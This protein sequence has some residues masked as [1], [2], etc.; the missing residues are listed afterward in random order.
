[1]RC[2]PLDARSL[3]S[4]ATIKD[5]H[6]KRGALAEGEFRAWLDASRLPYVYA[7][8]DQESVPQHFRVSM[9]RPDYLVALPYVATIAFDVKSKTI[10]EG[11]FLFDVSEVRRLAHFGELFAVASYF[12]C[13]DPQGSPISVWF[14]AS[15]LLQLPTRK[16]KGKPVCIVPF[17]HGVRLSMTRPFQDALRDAIT[18]S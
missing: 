13:L 6:A 15:E 16:I 14:R 17:S 5:Q 7:T 18:L 9:K 8:Q 3:F 11:D 1:M 10:Y 2:G 12:A 4:V